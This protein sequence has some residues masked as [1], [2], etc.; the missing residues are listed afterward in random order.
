M[1]VFGAATIF[2]V[3]D[4]ETALA[5]YKEV[6]GFEEEFRF[7]NYAGLK[8]GGCGLHLSAMNDMGRPVGG[9]TIY[10][11]CDAVDDYYAEVAAKG[12]R[13]V[14]PPM[15]QY[16]DMRDFVLKDPDGNQLSFGVDIS[17]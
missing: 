3:A 15:D 1:Q 8:R 2:Q 16:Y 13:I 17:G 14:Q 6:L 11:I 5:F 4:F 9:G 12:A 7:D 10:L